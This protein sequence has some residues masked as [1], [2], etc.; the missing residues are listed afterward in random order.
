MLNK[1]KIVQ[2]H[3]DEVSDL[4]IQ[5]EI[6]IN[7]YKILFIFANYISINNLF[8]PCFTIQNILL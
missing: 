5:P 4:I 8:Y 6:I 3:Y 7:T 2:Q 1:L